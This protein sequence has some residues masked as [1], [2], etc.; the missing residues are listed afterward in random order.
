MAEADYEERTA[1]ALERL[2]AYPDVALARI[3]LADQAIGI[4]ERAVDLVAGAAGDD[5][6]DLVAAAQE[7]RS[8]AARVAA[9]A[10]VAARAAGKSWTEIGAVL[11]VT[12]QAA[13]DRF[14][15]AE[16]RFKSGLIAPVAA[17]PLTLSEL[18]QGLSDP[19]ATVAGLDQWLAEVHVPRVF[20]DAEAPEPFST[21]LP[22]ADAATRSGDFSWRVNAV[23]KQRI[24]GGGI[25]PATEED[26]RLRRVAAGHETDDG[27]PISPFDNGPHRI[28]RKDSI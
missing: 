4:T 28:D 2:R 17:E 9:G 5:P 18:A 27:T 23:A 11:G 20:S 13:S 26:W 12:K 7:L 15:D 21:R 14:K 8:E 3:S 22:T 6:L 16:D 1:Q 24:G 25:S 10:V 19:A